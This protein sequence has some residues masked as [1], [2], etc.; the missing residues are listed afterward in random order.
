MRP[1]LFR[2]DQ[3]GIASCAALFC[4]CALIS[5]PGALHAQATLTAAS[6]ALASGADATQT[7][8]AAPA[9]AASP[10][11]SPRAISAKDFSLCD[12]A[13]ARRGGSAFGLVMMAT[14]PRLTRA[15]TATVTLWDEI[16]PPL[17]L[18]APVDAAHAMQGGVVSYRYK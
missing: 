8:I 9:G 16:A 14:P 2:V 1:A 3:D 15:R 10:H 6:N 12:Q 17:P 11:R 4:A 13:I 18:P 5:L 7:R